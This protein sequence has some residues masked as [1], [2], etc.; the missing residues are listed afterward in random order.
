MK[1]EINKA[2]D[3]VYVYKFYGSGE[4]SAIAFEDYGEK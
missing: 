4:A 3:D 2:F 1:F